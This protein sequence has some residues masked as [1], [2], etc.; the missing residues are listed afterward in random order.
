MTAFHRQ[1]PETRGS[2]KSKNSLLTITL[3]F[4]YV[5]IWCAVSDSTYVL[6]WSH[7]RCSYALF[8]RAQIRRVVLLSSC[9]LTYIHTFRNGTPPLRV[10]LSYVTAGFPYNHTWIRIGRSSKEHLRG[11]IPCDALGLFCCSKQTGICHKSVLSFRHFPNGQLYGLSYC[12]C[13]WTLFRIYHIYI[14]AAVLSFFPCPADLLIY[15]PYC[16]ALCF[17]FSYCGLIYGF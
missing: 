11:H 7:I 15:V 12:N 5:L 3:H 8:L 1:T 13:F 10:L 16:A 4:S 2:L 9:V 6:T 17:L 14:V